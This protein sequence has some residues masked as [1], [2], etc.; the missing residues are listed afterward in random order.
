MRNKGEGH[1]KKKETRKRGIK[2]ICNM[3]VEK[4]RKKRKKGREK[5]S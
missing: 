5:F 4:R 3:L 2:R 1:G